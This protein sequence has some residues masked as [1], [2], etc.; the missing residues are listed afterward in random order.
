MQITISALHRMALSLALLGSLAAQAQTEPPR[1]ERHPKDVSIHGER[2]ID[3]YFW[4]RERDRP[5]VQAYL[6][7]EAE[8]T[9]EWFKP[10]AGLRERLYQEMVGR[11]Q[12]ADEA[13]PVREGRW[14]Y[15]SRTLQGAQYPLYVRRAAQ[16]ADRHDDPAGPEQVLLDLNALAQGRQFLALDGMQVSPDGRLLAYAID[17]T[18][19]RDFQLQLRDI[20]AAKDLAWSAK[21][22]QGFAWAG[23]GRHLFY[24]TANE[25]KRADKLWRHR[26]DGHGPDELVFEEKDELFDLS[27]APSADRRFLILSSRSKDTQEQRVLAA[28]APTGPWR[29]VLPRRAGLEYKF[30]HRD[31]RFLLLSNDRGPNFRLLSLK[32]GALPLTPRALAGARELLPHSETAMLE[33]LQVFKRGLVLQVR[34]G[35]SVKLRLLDGAGGGAKPRELP[36]AEP[37]YTA[38][39]QAY[40]LPALNREYDS[41]TLRLA[42]Q[43]MT[44]P[45][46][47]YDYPLAG[48]ALTLRKVQPVLGG[49]DPKRYESRRLWATAKDGTRVPISIVYAKDLRRSGP[50]SLLL[51]GYGSYGISSDPRFV[52][53]NL[54]LLD[55][56]VIL[57]VAHI[58]GGGDLG[59]RWYLEGK[60]AKKMNTFT[61]FIACAEA[62]VAEGYTEPKQLII[63]GGSAGGLLMGAVVNL[64][65]ELFK[66][67]VMHV[68]FV[69]VIN[70]MLDESLPL[71]TGEFIEWGNPKI[72]EQY[73][74]MR[75]YSPYDNLKPD[76]YPAILARTGLNDSQVPYWEP[77]KYVA[78]LR[79]LKTDSNPLLFDINMSVGHGGASGRFDALKERAQY[80]AFMLQQWGLA[81]AKP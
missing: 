65:P 66:A 57:A 37:V 36:F 71:T 52:S 27:L 5:E 34:E 67:V 3:D 70:T 9:A 1:A 62:L 77:A 26:L 18:G 23:D 39:L 59:R 14:W 45:P 72:A 10:L 49:F 79:T 64:R 38:Q 55:R 73:A 8:Y 33:E 53:S 63:T 40:G 16:G 78:R 35:G 13:V 17:E 20:A 28:D 2:R 44:T 48:G 75:A 74:W 68:P 12:Q 50:Q 31:G 24:I 21:N 80:Y 46:S 29:L 4:L 25:A 15:T 76:A 69:D 19:A 81:D 11:I 7:A 32:A 6:K 42:Y 58:R 47:I 60:L 41:G 22:T 30:E 51:Q 61:D 54:A 56:G 43:S